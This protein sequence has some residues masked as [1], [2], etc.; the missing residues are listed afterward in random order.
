MTVTLR[1][2]RLGACEDTQAQDSLPDHG[3]GDGDGEAAAGRSG[4]TGTNPV[5]VRSALMMIS[6]DDYSVWMID[7]YH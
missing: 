4:T 2:L 7:R 3:D 6:D 1:G 5:I